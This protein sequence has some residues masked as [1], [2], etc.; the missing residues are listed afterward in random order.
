MQV[1]Q[2]LTEQWCRQS[3]KKRILVGWQPDWASE[4]AEC[5]RPPA[6]EGSHVIRFRTLLKH[7]K[8]TIRLL[9][10]RQA[11]L[12]PMHV[13]G[14]GNGGINCVG[15]KECERICRNRC[16][17]MH[18][19]VCFHLWMSVWRASVHAFYCCAQSFICMQSFPCGVFLCHVWFVYSCSRFSIFVR[20]RVFSEWGHLWNAW[21][22]W[23]A[24]FKM[25]ETVINWP[26]NQK[27]PRSTAR[28][29]LFNKLETLFYIQ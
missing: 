11:K 1:W 17:N 14:K 19:S 2:H 21:P 4:A 22:F 18:I 28:K 23:L 13:T 6:P 25:S 10:C 7:L 3:G 8:Q 5:A 9:C 20:T 12:I 29:L 27:A 24:L 15:G 16:L 26:E